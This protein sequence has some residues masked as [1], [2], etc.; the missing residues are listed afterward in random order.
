KG[1]AASAGGGLPVDEQGTSKSGGPP[2]Q[3]IKRGRQTP[4]EEL[5]KCPHPA[6]TT[7]LEEAPEERPPKF[8]LVVLETED[9]GEIRSS[10]SPQS[11]IGQE[12]DE[13][14]QSRPTTTQGGRRTWTMS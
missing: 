11:P 4:E 12:E 14:I 2:A 7:S 9:V 5:G 8:K 6:R 1:G 13:E 3:S 10:Q